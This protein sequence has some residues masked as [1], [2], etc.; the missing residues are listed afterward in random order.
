MVRTKDKG[1]DVSDI[2]LRWL[3]S[4]RWFVTYWAPIIM[5]QVILM[6]FGKLQHL[7]AWRTSTSTAKL[8]GSVDKKL[9]S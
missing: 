4:V 9:A 1:R 2:S 5:W 7:S 8:C 3:I 6:K